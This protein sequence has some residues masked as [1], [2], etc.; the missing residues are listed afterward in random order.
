M[1]LQI[2]LN[3]VWFANNSEKNGQRLKYRR[4]DSMTNGE[5]LQKESN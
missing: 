1:D 2:W 5:S 4:N 3:K